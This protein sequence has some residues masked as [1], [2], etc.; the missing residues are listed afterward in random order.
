MTGKELILYILQNN[1]ENEEVVIDDSLIGYLSIKE[2]AEKLNVGTST[3]L[4]YLRLG[5]L[6]YIVINGR[7]NIP[8]NFELKEKENNK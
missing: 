2:V 1:L 5:W 7:F 8:Y 4:A 6:P 3:V